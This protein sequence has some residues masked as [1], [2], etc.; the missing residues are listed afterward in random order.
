LSEHWRLAARYTFM[1]GVVAVLSGLGI[2]QHW[3]FPFAGAFGYGVVIGLASFVSTALSVSLL[4]GKS[5]AWRAVG[6]ASFVLRYGFVA[7]ALGVP[8]YLGAWPILAMLSGFAGVYLLEN[9][10]ILPAALGAMS[11]SAKGGGRHAEGKRRE[12]AES[13]DGWERTEKRVIV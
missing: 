9:V 7:V 13:S 1:V 11:R 3:G 4:T 8:A 2:W 12:G 6:G 5:V 10:V